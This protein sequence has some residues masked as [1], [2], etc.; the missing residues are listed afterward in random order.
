[1]QRVKNAAIEK[2]IMQKTAELKKLSNIQGTTKR[3]K[4]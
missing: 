2:S 3:V 4:G 1:M